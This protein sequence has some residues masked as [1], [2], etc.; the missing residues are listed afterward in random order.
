[1]PQQVPLD[2]APKHSILEWSMEEQEKT[3]DDLKA[4][5]DEA[6]QGKL[7]KEKIMEGIRYND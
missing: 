3:L 2:K 1:M 4:K 6:N 7:D 5:Y